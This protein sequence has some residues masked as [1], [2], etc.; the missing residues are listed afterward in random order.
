MILI[1]HC[2]D[3]GLNKEVIYGKIYKSKIKVTVERG[4][5]MRAVNLLKLA[6][7]FPLCNKES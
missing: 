5:S 7:L 1:T 6:L 3:T 4:I 2:C